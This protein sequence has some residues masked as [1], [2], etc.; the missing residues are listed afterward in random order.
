MSDTQWVYVV[1]LDYSLSRGSSPYIV[2]S[3]S[4]EGAVKLAREFAE[5]EARE[6]VT[7][8]PDDPDEAVEVPDDW[9]GS[10]I[11]LGYETWVSYER[12]PILD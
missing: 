5:D 4:R 12:L 6:S 9:D 2:V 1:M 3:G 8:D 10:S 7:A 11:E